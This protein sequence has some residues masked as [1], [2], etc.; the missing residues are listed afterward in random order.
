MSAA[1]ARRGV[2]LGTPDFERA[3]ERHCDCAGF[4]GGRF[5]L[6]VNLGT[7]DVSRRCE[8]EEGDENHKVW[9]ALA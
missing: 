8:G 2:P 4:G 6:S 1:R 9:C 3:D 5:R 7:G